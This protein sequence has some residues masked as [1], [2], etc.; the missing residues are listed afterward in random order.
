MYHREAYIVASALP[1]IHMFFVPL[2]VAAGAL[3]LIV[4]IILLV[5]RRR[6]SDSNIPLSQS[7]PVLARVFRWLLIV[8]GVLGAIQAAIGGLIWLLGGRPGDPL[9]FVYGGIVLLAIPVAYAYSDQ[10]RVRR[11]VIIMLIAAVAI[12]GAAIRALMTGAGLPPH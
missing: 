9:H 1:N 10:K 6:L 7:S 12:I 5:Q 4:A 2:V 3:T 8:T 11:D